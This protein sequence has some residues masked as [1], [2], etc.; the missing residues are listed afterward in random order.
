MA[1]LGIFG[2]NI[3]LDIITKKLD[4]N[5]T[6]SWCKGDKNDFFPKEVHELGYEYALYKFGLWSVYTDYEETRDINTVIQ[7]IYSL[8]ENKINE[9][10]EIQHEYN[11][12]CTILIVIKVRNEL[13][14]AMHFEK[15]FIDFLHDIHAEVDIDLYVYE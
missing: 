3:N 4:I 6:R 7:K 9:L 10:I 12:E 13:T 1:G 8:F 15:W 5:P 14:P 11:A 2:D